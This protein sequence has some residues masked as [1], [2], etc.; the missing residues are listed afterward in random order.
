[1]CEHMSEL[2]QTRIDY[3]YTVDY[4]VKKMIDPGEDFPAA[5][6]PVLKVDEFKKIFKLVSKNII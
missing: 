1:M 2:A 4:L 5:E 6:K 3:V